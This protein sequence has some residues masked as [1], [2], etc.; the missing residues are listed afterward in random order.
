MHFNE[1][2]NL[3][4]S[5][6]H[7]STDGSTV[8]LFVRWKPLRSNIIRRFVSAVPPC[9]LG[10][11]VCAHTVKLWESGGGVLVCLSWTAGWERARPGLHSAAG[12]AGS[13][14]C[15]GSGGRAPWATSTSCRARRSRILW[16]SCRSRSASRPRPPC[17]KTNVTF[18]LT[19][20]D[21]T[22]QVVVKALTQQS[23]R[24]SLSEFD[25]LWLGMSRPSF[26]SA[27]PPP[28]CVSYHQHTRSSP[29]GGYRLLA[30]M[31]LHTNR[32]I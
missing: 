29:L 16:T 13:T 18:S 5:D 19:C 30:C 10:C 17:G 3:V 25:C 8:S 24:R 9:P 15:G 7:P 22:E 28:L 6:Y 27:A 31:G 32:L 2:P 11:V 4:Q 21:E 1:K 14:T 23:R 12:C 20:L 26:L